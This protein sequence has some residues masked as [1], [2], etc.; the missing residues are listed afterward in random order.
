MWGTLVVFVR[1]RGFKMLPSFGFFKVMLSA[2]LR[3]GVVL[4]ASSG[5]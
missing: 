1:T 4:T 5:D 3:F 2:Y